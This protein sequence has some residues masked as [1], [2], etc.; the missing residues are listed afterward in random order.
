MLHLFY[1]SLEKLLRRNEFIGFPDELFDELWD[2]Q[3][4]N[5]PLSRRIIHEIDRVEFPEGRTTEEA[6]ALRG[7][8]LTDL[9]TGTKNLLVCKN[10][11]GLNRMTMMGDNCYPFLMDIADQREVYMGCSNYVLF[12]DDILKGRTVHFLNSDLYASNEEAFTRCELDIVGGG[13][14]FYD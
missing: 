1:E 7:M 3:W 6:C 4:V 14:I 9:C 2:S 11:S 5:N 12:D 13:S 10:Y 8:C